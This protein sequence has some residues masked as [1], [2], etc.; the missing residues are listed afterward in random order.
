MFSRLG[1]V[2]GC[3]V[4]ALPAFGLGGTIPVAADVPC[5]GSTRV[6]AV[7]A[8][9]GHLAELRPCQAGRTW[10]F[11]PAVVVDRAD[12]R[13]YVAVV[14]MYDG[15]AAVLYA[16]TASGE[17]WWRRQDTPGAATGSPVRIAGGIGPRHDVV[18]AAGPGRLAIGDHG[19]PLRTYRH[20]GWTTGGTQV[21]E[22]GVLFS[23]FRGPAI[24]GLGAGYA[25]GTWDGMDYRVWRDQPGAGHDDV[26]YPSG[27]LPAG[28][29]DATGDGVLLYG[30]HASGDVVLLAQRQIAACRRA[31]RA[32]W[33]VTARAPGHF[34]RVV[35]PVEVPAALVPPPPVDPRLH[36]V[37]GGSGVSP[38]EWQ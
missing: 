18:L 36:E 4:M 20:D 23:A 26:W 15:D 21:T 10:R 9:T 34:G 25:V 31:E 2:V 16:V 35:V 19:S 29:R 3:L 33:R 1:R 6:F 12:W 37:C 22:D 38:W 27:A 14:A 32:D 24:T 30:V 5:S 8:G 28:V 11:G 17:L 7:D 13:S